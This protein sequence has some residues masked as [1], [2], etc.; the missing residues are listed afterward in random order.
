MVGKGG[1][2]KTTTAG[3]LALASADRGDSTHL[4]STDPAPSLADLFEVGLPRGR[5][6][7]SPCAD[8]LTLEELDAQGYADRWIARVRAPLLELVD[9]GTYLD[10]EDVAGFLDLSLPGV[11]EIAAVLRLADLAGDA[12]SR[13]VFVDTAPT[14]HTLRLLDASSVL[15]SWAAAFQAMEDKA[16]AVL[17]GLMHR[18]VRLAAHE[19]IRDLEAGIERFRGDVLAHGQAVVVERSGRLVQAETLRLRA[20]LARRG[21]PVSARVL[22]LAPG[23]IPGPPAPDTVAVPW[24]ERLVGCEPLRAWGRSAGRG[25]A[26]TTPSP[27]TEGPAAPWLAALD[28]DLVLFVGK[29]G[30]GKTTCAAAAA[31]GLA[32]AGLP[33]V[34]LGT[35]PAGS[36]EDVLQHPIPP[37]GT[38]VGGVRVREIQAGIEFERFRE[39]YRED[40]EQAFA[41]L[42][43][44]QGLALDRRVVASLLD[45]APPGADEIFAVL[46]LL[47]EAAPDSVLIVDAA[48]TGHL[49]RLLEMPALALGWTRQLMR[50]LVKYRAALGLDAFAERLLDFAKQL[51]ELNLRLHDPARTAALVVSIPG[52]LVEAQS[53]RLEQRLEKGAVRVAARVLNRA[54]G[55]GPRAAGSSSAR[56]IRAPLLDPPPLG[57]DALS[58]FFHRWTIAPAS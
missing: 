28:A 15:R 4:L 55:P 22:T 52:P 6:T 11:D 42:G 14:G 25:A 1:V 53:A 8:R 31:V 27:P 23:E 2:G 19:V 30:V 36:L 21:L 41:R 54:A 34:L 16:E 33:V 18:T 35:D 40:V 12:G 50:V 44:A 37:E 49:L 46:A 47:D 3:A 48:P 38:T 5:T 10:S 24:Q 29:G 20:A 26:P 45:L 56:Q 32:R 43:A 58:D 39:R 7:P 51:K 57:P 13:R 9:R 17:S